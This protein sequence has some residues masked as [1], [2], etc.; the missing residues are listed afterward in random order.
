MKSNQS[1]KIKAKRRK[2]PAADKVAKSPASPPELPQPVR[3]QCRSCNHKL[4]TPHTNTTGL[5]GKCSQSTTARDPTP[6]Q[7]S[8]RSAKVRETWTEQRWKRARRE[9]MA[10]LGVRPGGVKMDREYRVSSDGGDVAD[11]EV[12]QSV[13][14]GGY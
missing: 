7:I 9:A 13:C 8:E 4:Q 2:H 11:F 1:R 6:D 3:R 5:C 12:S 10:A 14:I